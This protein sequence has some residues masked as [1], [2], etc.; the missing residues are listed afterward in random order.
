MEENNWTDQGSMNVP[1]APTATV[2]PPGSSAVPTPAYVRLDG[3]LLAPKRHT[4]GVTRPHYMVFGSYQIG[5]YG[6]PVSDDL[7]TIAPGGT[8]AEIIIDQLNP[9]S[10]DG[11]YAAG[12]KTEGPY[13]LAN[14]DY[15]YLFYSIGDCCAPPAYGGDVVYRVEVC[16]ADPSG[17]VT[18]PYFDRDGN[19]C[20]TGGVDRPGTIVLY[21]TRRFN[22]IHYGIA[23]GRRADKR[24]QPTAKYSL[25]AP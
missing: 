1:I 2:T 12:N 17:D 10:P 20:L 14:G 21:S 18:G 23:G 24:S 3:S 16:R 22:H 15:I 5:L 19:D 6:F 25:Q 9:A 13:M 7:L 8:V 4:H 11:T